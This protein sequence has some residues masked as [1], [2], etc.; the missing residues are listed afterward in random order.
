MHPVQTT[1]A[2]NRIPLLVGIAVVLVIAVLAMPVKQRCGAPGYSCATALDAQGY[3]H[4]Y[5]EVEPLGVYLAEIITGSNIR[6]Y[7]TSGE[8]LVKVRQPDRP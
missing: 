4:Y 6:L 3:V 5:Y 1:H 7:Y 2:L 8:E